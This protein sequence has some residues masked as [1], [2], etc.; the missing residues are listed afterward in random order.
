MNLLPNTS[1]LAG[2][3]RATPSTSGGAPGAA[4]EGPAFA[5]ALD[6][7]EIRQRDGRT[8]EPAGGEGATAAEAAEKAADRRERPLAAAVR[9]VP[10]ASAAGLATA[11]AAASDAKPPVD[12]TPVESTPDAAPA[13]DGPPPEVLAAWISALPLPRGPA[14]QAAAA[15]APGAVDRT[16]VADRAAPLSR[17]AAEA[18]PGTGIADTRGMPAPAEPVLPAQAT[19]VDPAARSFPPSLPALARA[20]G[21]PLAGTEASSGSSHEPPTPALPTL[22]SAA[23]ATEA[24]PSLPAL[25]AA[26]A[27]PLPAAPAPAMHSAELQAPVGSREF[28][29]A[30]AGQV[31]IMVRDGIEQAQLKLNPAELGPI[32][33]R[34]RIDGTQAQVDFSAAHAATRQAL[35][36]AVPA[37]AGTL[38]ENGLTLTGG[39]V[40]EQPRDPRGE[41]RPDTPRSPARFGGEAHD[42]RSA[43]PAAPTR[44][45]RVRGMLDLYA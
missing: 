21:R 4:D 7:A 34:I 9:N 27:A 17:S 6:A 35:Q 45:A 43:V 32:E 28:A 29:P 33:V 40:F 16:D 10:A 14:T 2:P 37:L 18:A 8:E 5:Q 24:S 22:Q 19:A 41:S 20:Q 39:G 30:L 26:W 36:E 38:R 42:D 31:S 13:A 15:G 1:P 23:P 3:P 11:E 25:A 12:D 44:T